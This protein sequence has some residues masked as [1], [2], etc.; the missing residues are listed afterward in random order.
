[1]PP[2]TF[3]RNGW[4]ILLY[5]AFRSQLLVLY[6][7]VRRVQEQHPT[8]W[9]SNGHA[10]LLNRIVEITLHEVPAAPE[11]PAF[12]QGNTI[13]RDARGWRRVK[14]LGRFR[15]F[16]RFN[17]GSKV[18]IN[19]WVNDETT[20][21]ARGS[22]SDPYAVFRRM[23]LAGDPPHNWDQLQAAS[24]APMTQPERDALNDLLG[25]TAIAAPVPAANRSGK[26]RPRKR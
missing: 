2:A 12:E 3:R 8:S 20:L 14:F 4:T 6:Q 9:Q 26:S 13:G 1:M 7:R 22:D 17:S 15:L 19:V 21:R 11:S 25:S 5:P 23:L 18:I 16:Y 24:Q 10:K